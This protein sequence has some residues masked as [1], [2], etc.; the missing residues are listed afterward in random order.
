MCQQRGLGRVVGFDDDEE[1]MTTAYGGRPHGRRSFES[2]PIEEP[3][4]EDT[5]SLEQPLKPHWLKGL[6]KEAIH[7]F[8]QT[9]VFSWNRP[10]EEVDLTEMMSQ[11]TEASASI[12]FAD[13]MEEPLDDHDGTVMT[14]EG[15]EVEIAV[16]EKGSML[17]RPEAATGAVVKP[18][19][20]N[21]SIRSKRSTRTPQHQ[22]LQQP[23]PKQ[24]FEEVLISGTSSRSNS[25]NEL[26]VTE[27]SPIHAKGGASGASLDRTKKSSTTEESPK[28]V[29]HT[30]RADR[31][32]K[33]FTQSLVDM[34]TNA[35]T[36]TSPDYR[37][38]DTNA[39]IIPSVLEA[40][41]DVGSV[42]D[43]T[44]TT[45]EMQVEMAEFRKQLERL[46][47]EAKEAQCSQI[48]LSEMDA[49][50]EASAAKLQVK[51]GHYI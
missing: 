14:D 18:A 48:S 19:S 3:G 21:A 2:D 12:S 46:Q 51:G 6:N 26:V 15:T 47:K 4:D 38:D 10:K 22:L 33:S 49:A 24:I 50:T 32:V 16:T 5:V 27:H 39:F 25:S 17:M 43:L 9:P 36:P 20:S 30:P 34:V 44:A 42:G 37:K 8:G 7:S 31:N 11:T 1:T 29:M 23:Q 40:D 35:I 41:F 13:D 28:N 45:L